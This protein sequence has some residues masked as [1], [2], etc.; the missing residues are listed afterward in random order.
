MMEE[1]AALSFRRAFHFL[2]SALAALRLFS[3]SAS[4]ELWS[5]GCARSEA[6]DGRSDGSTVSIFEMSSFASGETSPQ[7]SGWNSKAPLRISLKSSCRL[8][9]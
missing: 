7:N 6:A 5:H 1:A 2:I 8:S 9:W 3:A 4:A